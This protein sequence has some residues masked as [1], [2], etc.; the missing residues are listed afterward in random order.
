MCNMKAIPGITSGELL[1]RL[2][3]F[4][5][6]QGQGHKVKNFGTKWKVLSQAMHMCNMIQALR[7]HTLVYLKAVAT[8]QGSG[9]S[10]KRR[11]Y[12]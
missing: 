8:V 10:F 5:K 9:Y 4:S 11:G 2:K 12:R 7:Y 1:P 6:L 3:F